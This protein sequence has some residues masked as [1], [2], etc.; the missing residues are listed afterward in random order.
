MPGYE[1]RWER[2]P[3]AAGC[4]W[5]RRCLAMQA[6]RMLVKNTI[7]G[8][9]RSKEDFLGFAGRLGDS[10]ESA[11]TEHVAQYVRDLCIRES[12]AQPKTVHI[13]ARAGLSN[14]AVHLRLTV[15]RLFYDLLVEEGVRRTNPVG[16]SNSSRNTAGTAR[17]KALFH[18]HRKRP[19]IPSEEQWQAI[20]AVVRREPLRNRLMLALSYDAAL[21]RQELLGLETADIDPAHRLLHIRAER[22]KNGKADSEPW[23]F[24]RLETRLLHI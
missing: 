23:R 17:A 1:P 14:A 21:R 8:Y 4:E 10:P 12:P 5:A 16:H 3:T 6:N 19:W 11:T 7:D 2:F 22:T 13:D 15:V 24:L 18:R 20:L 9:S